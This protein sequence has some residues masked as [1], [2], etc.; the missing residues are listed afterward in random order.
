MRAGLQGVVE[1]RWDA[2]HVLLH[3]ALH[4]VLHLTCVVLHPE[5]LALYQGTG[6]SDRQTRAAVGAVA[7]EKGGGRRKGMQGC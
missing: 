3:P 1:R 7:A 5:A 6:P 2:V 4:R